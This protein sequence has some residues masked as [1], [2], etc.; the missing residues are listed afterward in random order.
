MRVR[1]LV[2]EGFRAFSNR[3][4]IDLNAD[5]VLVVG[6]NGQ[7]KTSLLEL[8]AMAGG[9]EA[10]SDSTVLV[11]RTTSGKRSAAKFDVG[12]IQKGKADDPTMQ[13]GDI[14]VAGES[15]IRKGFNNV[16]KALPIAGLFALL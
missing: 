14:V 12:T 7:G 1:S 8:V 13:A 3:T 10:A 6:S 15:A 16:L 5:V 9:F 4:L 11:L 2:V